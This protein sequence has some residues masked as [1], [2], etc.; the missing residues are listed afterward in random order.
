VDVEEREP[1]GED[2]L[3]GPVPRVGEAVEVGGDRAPRQHRAL[4][5]PG[6]P[7]RVDD[8]RR[9]LVAGVRAGQLAPAGVDVDGERAWC[10][11][12]VAG[13]AD[14]DIRLGVG[15]DV[16]E[17]A[18]AELRVDRDER[19]AGGERGHRGHARLERRLGPHRDALR[20]VELRG[21]R[22][23]GLAQL[24]VGEAAVA[25]RDGGLAAELEDALQHGSAG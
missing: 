3:T 25:D 6:G 8:Q 9:V 4:G 20:A 17:L 14:D 7:A 10:V 2:V 1:V 13:R 23:G 15:Q 19:D 21:E 18:A 24:A 5:L 12:E 16:L 11:G 22:S